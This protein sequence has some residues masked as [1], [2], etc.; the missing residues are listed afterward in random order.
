MIINKKTAAPQH[1]VVKV[2]ACR[3]HIPED[4][5]KMPKLPKTALSVWVVKPP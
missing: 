4:R 3:Y 5:A 1:I 2:A